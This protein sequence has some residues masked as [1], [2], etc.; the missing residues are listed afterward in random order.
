MKIIKI[1][2]CLM[3]CLLVSACNLNRANNHHISITTKDNGSDLSF[4]A[5][6]PTN[7]TAAVQKYIEQSLKE[8]RIFNSV[9]DVKKA[10]ITL[11]DGTWFYLNYEPGFISIN[12]DR[13]KNSFT[14]YNRMKTMIAG[15]GNVIKD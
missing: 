8:E 11:T 1:L 4:K 14:A 15:F 13:A 2:V 10:E 12:F 7:R 9:S 6:Y 5:D 3:G